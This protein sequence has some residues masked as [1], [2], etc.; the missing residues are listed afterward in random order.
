MDVM[1]VFQQMVI[2]FILVLVGFLLM[3]LHIFSDEAGKNLSALVTNVCNPALMLSSVLDESA[4]VP[5]ENLALM[6]VV[7]LAVYVVLVILG[8]LIPR[9]IRV[10]KKE[11]DYYNLLTL[12]GNTGFI[13]IPVVSALLGPSG[14]V[15]VVVFNLYFVL[16]VYTYGKFLVARSD[17][18]GLVKFRPLDMVNVGSI[19]CVLSIIVYVCDLHL[20]VVLSESVSYMGRATTFVSMVVIGISLAQMPLR[21]TFGDRHIYLFVL[22]RQLLVSI[23]MG[24][25]LRNFVSDE[26][27]YGVLL[28][29]LSV[30]AG[31]LPLMFVKEAGGD[32]EVLSRGIVVTTI[33]SVITIPIVVFF[34][35]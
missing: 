17:E 33:F 26:I 15:Y 30:P 31:N 14:V 24:L 7:S 11:R 22:V 32:G 28:I 19:G 27:V 20:P 18:Q 5:K 4:D 13:G 9:L 21:A 35:V 25:V 3:K 8:L 10:P 1:V 2:I 6:A 23:A 34:C 29:M 16:L 12:F